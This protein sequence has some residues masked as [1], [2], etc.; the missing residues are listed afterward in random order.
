MVDLKGNIGETISR[1]HDHMKEICALINCGVGD[2]RLTTYRS[3]TV[4]AGHVR[5]AGGL[6]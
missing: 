2:V 6:V 5:G 1:Y 3:L 4:G